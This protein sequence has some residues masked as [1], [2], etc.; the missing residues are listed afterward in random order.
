[1]G[2]RYDHLAVDWLPEHCIDDMLSTEFEHAGP[3]NNGSWPYWTTQ[4][5]GEFINT[6]DVNSYAENAIDYWAT[7][8]WHIQHCIFTWR[9]QFR[10]QT[11]GTTIEPWNNNEEHI[12]HCGKYLLKTVG[13]SRSNVDTLILGQNR[14]QQEAK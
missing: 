12:T 6:E 1:M 3:E 14:H 4:Y 9:K 8:E 7:R 2:C 13:A 11:L 10:A 5:D